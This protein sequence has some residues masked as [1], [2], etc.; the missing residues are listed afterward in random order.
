VWSCEGCAI[1][2]YLSTLQHTDAS[3]PSLTA[4][5]VR[6]YISAGHS[7]RERGKREWLRDGHPDGALP[8]LLRRMA[9][10]RVPIYECVDISL[11]EQAC[12][13]HDIVV[14]KIRVHNVTVVHM[15]QTTQGMQKNPFSQ[16][17]R[18]TLF[19]S[20]LDLETLHVSTQKGG[21]EA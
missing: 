10:R 5:K 11:C 15:C 2:C 20:S 1:E 12:I 19:A 14:L 16:G 4:A 13:E 21:N 6:N 9:P 18:K 8:A 3:Q 7:V 17:E